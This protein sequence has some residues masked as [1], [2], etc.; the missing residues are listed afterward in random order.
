MWPSPRPFRNHSA[1]VLCSAGSIARQ[2]PESRVWRRSSG[3][4]GHSRVVSAD[5]AIS[6]GAGFRY[7]RYGRNA[8]TESGAD[9]LSLSAPD[10]RIASQQATVGVDVARPIGR[11]GLRA[12]TTYQRE[13]T[14]GRTTT[15]LQ[16]ADPVDGRFVVDGH[17]LGR[18]TVTGE[19][20]AA[21]RMKGAELWLGYQ[22]RHA[23]GQTR[24]ALQLGLRF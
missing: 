8:W 14:N 6:P 22:A 12:S 7:G 1:V 3:L 10:Q 9:A 19:V 2:R 5:W 20:G 21:L 17:P 15:T 11:L 13:L 23:L 24:Q 18:D 4:T 16:L